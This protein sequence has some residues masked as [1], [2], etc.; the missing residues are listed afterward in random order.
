MS[1]TGDMK[2]VIGIR[3]LVTDK[4]HRFPDMFAAIGIGASAGVMCGVTV[5]AAVIPIVVLHLLKSRRKSRDAM[6]VEEVAASAGPR[7]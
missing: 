1:Y 2:E 6:P 3:E 4:R 5:G 7:Q